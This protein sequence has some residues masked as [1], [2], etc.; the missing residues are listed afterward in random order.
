MVAV[1]A[2]RPTQPGQDAEGL[3]H[4][5]ATALGPGLGV[6]SCTD[7]HND[8]P[9]LSRSGRGA[10]PLGLG[11]DHRPVNKERTGQEADQPE[12]SIHGDISTGERF[13]GIRVSSS[14]RWVRWTTASPTRSLR[15]LP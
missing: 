2:R 6:K 11:T 8:G 14:R 1:P 12:A 3:L 15:E 13:A 4:W 10:R 5:L 9:G 7:A